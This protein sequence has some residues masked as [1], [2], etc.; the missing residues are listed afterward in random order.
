MTAPRTI[1]PNARRHQLERDARVLRFI[2]TYVEAHG[3]APGYRQMADGL[4]FGSTSTAHVAVRRLIQR[5]Y[6]ESEPG[7]ARTLRVR[8]GFDAFVADVGAS[9]LGLGPA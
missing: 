7:Q 3:Y 4:D 1:N 8:R 6:L 2:E 9:T 5:G